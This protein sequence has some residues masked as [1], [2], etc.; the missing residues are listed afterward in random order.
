MNEKIR[1][2]LNL[3]RSKFRE[4]LKLSDFLQMRRGN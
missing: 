2:L 4:I 3:I 1:T